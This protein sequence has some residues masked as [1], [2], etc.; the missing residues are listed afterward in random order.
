M[1]D[2]K[3]KMLVTF[4]VFSSP[5]PT[6]N[7]FSAVLQPLIVLFLSV[8]T[9]L[10]HAAAICS[11][12]TLKNIFYHQM[13]YALKLFELKFVF[14]LAIKDKQNKNFILSKN[15]LQDDLKVIARLFLSVEILF[16]ASKYFSFE[17][18][19]PNIMSR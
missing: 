15:N 6:A 9:S 12:V 4:Q 17:I 8:F 18:T 1:S 19:R 10:L 5:R 2:C 7:T 14:F 11:K 13:A 16:Q 3:A